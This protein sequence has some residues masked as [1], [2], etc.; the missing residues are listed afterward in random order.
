MHVF[1]SLIL[2]RVAIECSMHFMPIHCMIL[3]CFKLNSD[4]NVS[5]EN[6]YL[7]VAETVTCA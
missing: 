6:R 7:F 4:S 1:R 5:D 3:K 2:Y